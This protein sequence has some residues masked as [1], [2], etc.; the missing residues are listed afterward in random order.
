MLKFR[1][2][3]GRKGHIGHPVHTACLRRSKGIETEPCVHKEKAINCPAEHFPNFRTFP[4]GR[5]QM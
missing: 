5:I 2:W 3:P 1:T 4:K